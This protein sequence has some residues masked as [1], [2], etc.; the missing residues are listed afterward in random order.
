MHTDAG[1]SRKWRRLKRK[2]GV[3]FFIS[4]LVIAA[5]A[6]VGFIMYVLTSPDFRIR[7]TS[8]GF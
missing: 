6:F 7:W 4:L 5:V 8:G 3:P 2:Y 1:R